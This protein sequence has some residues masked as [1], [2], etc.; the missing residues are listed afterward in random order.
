MQK[1]VSNIAPE[2]LKGPP[3]QQLLEFRKHAVEQGIPLAQIDKY[4]VEQDWVPAAVKQ[5]IRLSIDNTANNTAVSQ[6]GVESGYTVEQQGLHEPVVQA[7]KSGVVVQPEGI[8]GTVKIEGVLDAK[9]Q[10]ERIKE[11]FGPAETAGPKDTEIQDQVMQT[12]EQKEQTTTG[13]TQ[14]S[15]AGV[16]QRIAMSIQGYLPSQTVIVNATKLASQGD[17]KEAKTWQGALVQRIHEMWSNLK[18][19]VSVQEVGG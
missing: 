8:K 4:L 13:A 9:R 12:A 11:D 1:P 7:E 6:S 18:G 19:F 16:A 3:E 5:L 2:V 10:M 17:I 14:G 15:S